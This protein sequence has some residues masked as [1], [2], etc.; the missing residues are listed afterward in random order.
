MAASVG[1]PVGGYAI[2]GPRTRESVV[3]WKCRDSGP[4]PREVPF[5]TTVKCPNQHARVQASKQLAFSGFLVVQITVLLGRGADGAAPREP[6]TTAKA[7]FVD[8][9]AWVP[10]VTVVCLLMFGF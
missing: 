8:P 10:E 1:V 7:I 5:E 3:I 6:G 4:N 2:C 9:D